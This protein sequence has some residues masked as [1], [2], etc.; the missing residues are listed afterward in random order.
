MLALRTEDARV[1]GLGWCRSWCRR[2][3]RRQD[4][5]YKLVDHRLEIVEED[6]RVQFASLD[7]SELVL[8]FSRESG[9]LQQVVVDELDKLTTRL[10]SVY[11]IALLLD[12]VAT[13]EEGL[14]DIGSCR[15]TA[16]TVFLHRFT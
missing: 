13:L 14:D 10:S 8:P 6:L 1:Y 12:D 3:L 7:L 11:L 4:G 5:L 2:G 16:N 15:R 9:T